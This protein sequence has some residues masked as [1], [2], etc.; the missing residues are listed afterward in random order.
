MQRKWVASRVKLETIHEC[1]FHPIACPSFRHANRLFRLHTKLRHFR[2][3]GICLETKAVQWG[4][5]C[6][7]KDTATV[8]LPAATVVH[9]DV[10]I[11]TCTNECVSGVCIT[12]RSCIDHH[13]NDLSKMYKGGIKQQLNS[14]N[15]C[16]NFYMGF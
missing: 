12:F 10:A 6:G 8:I 5:R 16:V 11:D 9:G 4:C 3:N 14:N 7:E 2:H 15:V 1:H 13:W